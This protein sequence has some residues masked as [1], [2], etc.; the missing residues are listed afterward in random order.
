[1]GGCATP[2]AVAPVHSPHQLHP[3]TIVNCNL[4]AREIFGED[5]G[6]FEITNNFNGD[7]DYSRDEFRK[8]FSIEVSWHFRKYFSAQNNSSPQYTE[9]TIRDHRHRQ[10]LILLYSLR[11]RCGKSV[12]S[13]IGV[14]I[15][16]HVHLDIRTV[17]QMLGRYCRCQDGIVD[18]RYQT[19]SDSQS[20]HQRY[21]TLSLLPS[22]LYNIAVAHQRWTY[23]QPM[24]LQSHV[25]IASQPIESFRH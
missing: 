5:L 19:L 20:T 13:S 24:T 16:L 18:A 17:L 6:M 12:T 25:G 14:C 15:D 1:M 7:S 22:T 21:S 8:N 9:N 23:S 10:S 4:F 3:A 11:H 2:S